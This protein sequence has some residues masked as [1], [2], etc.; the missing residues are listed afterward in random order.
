VAWAPEPNER[1]LEVSGVEHVLDGHRDVILVAEDLQ[2]A[3]PA[4]ED[5]I[6]T[7]VGGRSGQTRVF[8]VLDLRVPVSRSRLPQASVLER[9]ADELHILRRHRPQY[10]AVG[11]SR[12]ASSTV[13]H[14]RRTPN[15]SF[16]AW[17]RSSLNLAVI[18]TFGLRPRSRASSSAAR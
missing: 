11:S 6:A 13:T 7:S 15:E 8:D 12:P 17:P 16:E 1:H 5:L 2:I 14:L 18:F 10:L 4:A 9:P 3:L